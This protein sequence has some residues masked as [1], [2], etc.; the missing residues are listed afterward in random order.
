MLVLSP[1]S[2][3]PSVSIVSASDERPHPVNPFRQ[4]AYYLKAPCLLTKYRL[5]VIE[6]G[7]MVTSRGN[8][9]E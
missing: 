3:P 1:S 9:K 2:A 7:M 8:L 4:W 5:W 6:K